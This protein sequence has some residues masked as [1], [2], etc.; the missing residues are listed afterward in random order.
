MHTVAGIGQRVNNK[1]VS[2]NG[3]TTENTA[4]GKATDEYP[5]LSSQDVLTNISEENQAEK[6]RKYTAFQAYYILLFLLYFYI[7]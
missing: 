7:T 3:L 4:P 2:R 1:V 5:P 6:Y